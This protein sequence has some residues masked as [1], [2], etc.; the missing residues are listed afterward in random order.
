MR[1]HPLF[2]QPLSLVFLFIRNNVY[3]I[4]EDRLSLPVLRLVFS[5]SCSRLRPKSNFLR[6]VS[7]FCPVSCRHHWL[8]SKKEGKDWKGLGVC[9]VVDVV[10]HISESRRYFWSPTDLHA[11][12]VIK[13]GA[14]I[15]RIGNLPCTRCFAP[16]WTSLSSG[17]ASW[18]SGVNQQLFLV[19]QGW[20][21]QING[22]KVE[23]GSLDL[24]AEKGGS[25]RERERL[26]HYPG[27]GYDLFY[28]HDSC[29]FPEVYLLWCSNPRYN[30]AFPWLCSF[31]PNAFP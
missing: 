12:L 17:L 4:A 27:K 9:P 30:H 1:C 7:G 13:S 20:S 18:L 22:K 14:G 3:C 15:P 2:H 10:Y 28:P 5:E 16:L 25:L 23:E 21:L 11:F 8:A 24:D 29:F 31:A 19:W 6:R 26:G